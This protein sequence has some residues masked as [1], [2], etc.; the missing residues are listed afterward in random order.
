[1]CGPQHMENIFISNMKIMKMWKCKKEKRK[2]KEIY[3]ISKVGTI[4][5]CYVT[6]GKIIRKNEIRLI[7]DGI[8]I[9]TG[10]IKQLKRFKEDINEVKSGYECGLSI[11]DY[12]DIKVGDNIESFEIKEIKF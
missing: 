10:K 7:R 8:V 3:K 4:A 5:G 9:F 1:M 12:N 2:Y 11:E 6:N